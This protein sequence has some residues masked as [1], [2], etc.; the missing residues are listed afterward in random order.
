MNRKIIIIGLIIVALFLSGCVIEPKPTA[1]DGEV[2][3]EGINAVID[4]N[5][6]FAFDLYSEYKSEEGN[7]FFS[8][9]SI[10]TA[11][12][13][14]YEGAKGQTAKEMQ[15]VFHFPQDD[16]ERRSA[17]AGIYNEI[18]KKD[19][20]YELSTANALWAQKDFA[21]LEEYIEPIEQYYRG[22]ITNLD[23]VTRTEESRKTINDWVEKQTND[24]IKDLIPPGSLNS[25][26][27]LVLTNAI[28]FKGDWVYQ[29][30]KKNTREDDFKITENN[31]VKVP[32]M[33]LDNDDAKFN[34]AQTEDFQIL[35][36]PYKGEELSMLILLP[37]DNIKSIESSLTSE[38]LSEWK[39]ML[40]KEEVIIY[41]PK[42]TFKTKYFMS[43]ALVDMGM[44][45]AFSGGAD[46]SGM[47]GSKDLFISFVIHQ[48]FVDVNEEGT[49]AA[50]ATAAG[51]QFTAV[52]PTNIFRADHPFIF[53]IQEKET[54][55][56][57]F[58]GRVV[59][60]SK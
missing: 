32:M 20:G 18:N 36:M 16:N 11:L 3:Q 44:P 27:R 57:L 13:M 24:K 1:D 9:Y 7:I 12:A 21:F 10:S 60:P 46:F 8:P 54:G 43:D 39:N 58:L 59:D 49:E 52:M 29:F 25:M 2:T 55:N 56:I 40:K 53:I 47:T 26:T 17:F 41:M 14:T 15:S 28:Y 45:T 50:A 42:F 51:M 31:I 23:F 48:A 38:K 4:A 30:D 22:K 19:K 35:E 37:K 33:H 34:Y 5:N 6:Q